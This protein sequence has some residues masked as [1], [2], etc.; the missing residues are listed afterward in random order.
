MDAN[1]IGLVLYTV[2]DRAEEDFA[3]MLREVAAIGYGCAEICGT[4]GLEAKAVRGLGEELGLRFTSAHL[5][6]DLLTD[7]FDET[8]A[9][10]T[11]V[12]V[13]A[14]VVPWLPEERRSTVEG[15][16][17]TAKEL[18]EI[19]AR[20]KDH[21][22]AFLFHNHDVVFGPCDGT[23][24]WDILVAESDPASFN[25]EV[26]VYWAAYGGRDPMEVLR[27][28]PGRSPFIHVKDMAPDR[29]M[30]EVGAG[31]LDFAAMAAARQELGIGCFLVEHDEPTLPSMESARKSFEYLV[32]I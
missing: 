11:E 27:G 1:E 4:F 14:L 26:D 18:S 22:L 9:Y 29:A 32:G 24:A 5:G 6:L 20:L 3:G 30:T 12:G 23:T 10:Y 17:K 8:V 15:A 2:R 13:D 25:F 7:K 28:I 21:G 31:T 16:T 19:G